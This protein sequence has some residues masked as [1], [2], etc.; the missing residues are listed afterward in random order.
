[1]NVAQQKNVRH[2]DEKLGTEGVFEITSPDGSAGI[3]VDVATGAV[4]SIVSGVES[5]NVVFMSGLAGALADTVNVTQ[6]SSNGAITVTTTYNGICTITQSF[7]TD[8][9]HRNAVGWN[10]GVIGLLQNATSLPVISAM[11][12]DNAT[13]MNTTF[14]APW[15]RG[16]Y[17]H[18]NE[19]IDPL[20]PSDGK[21]GF[22]PG[23]YKYGTQYKSSDQKTESDMIVAPLMAVLRPEAHRGFSI[24]MSPEDPGTAF[25]EASLHTVSSGFMWSREQLQ[26]SL[27][28]PQIFSA[29]IVAHEDCW[30]PAAAFHRKLY[31][32]HWRPKT[33]VTSLDRVDGLGSYG[34]YPIPELGEVGDLSDPK[35]KRMNYK[36]CI[37]LAPKLAVVIQSHILTPIQAWLT[38]TLTLTLNPD[39]KPLP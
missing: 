30:R 22:W 16:S 3:K 18:G 19:W 25:A 37:F 11:S 39:T 38:L 26:I 14:W 28:T 12:M 2:Q 32:K 17:V 21:R 1:M 9:T 6:D 33:S 5:V 4:V 10:L 23:D 7:V 8:D 34:S 36:D 13:A 27:S 35:F 15:D 24:Q 20:L 29:H 31:P